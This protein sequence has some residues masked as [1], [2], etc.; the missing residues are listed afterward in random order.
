MVRA[1]VPHPHAHL[2]GA[3]YPSK[4]GLI[5]KHIVKHVATYRYC[6][7]P[8]VP[9]SVWR[10]TEQTE[11][12]SLPTGT[13]RCLESGLPRE[14]TGK[15]RVPVPYWGL[16]SMAT[17][18]KH[19]NLSINHSKHQSF[20]HVHVPGPDWIRPQKSSHCFSAGNALLR[21]RTATRN[22]RYGTGNVLKL[23]SLLFSGQCT[24]NGL[25]VG[26]GRGLRIRDW[27]MIGAHRLASNARA[28]WR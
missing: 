19:K 7:I 6:S 18:L 12:C 2:R 25:R 27:K 20:Y 22:N 16:V 17:L 10:G 1:F 4:S 14:I 26:R 3:L 24:S 5:H 13:L 23:F 11:C 15:V 28:P 8:T 9:S 21:V